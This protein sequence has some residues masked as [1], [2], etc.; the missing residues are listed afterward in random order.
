MLNI[1]NA[2]III[3][4]QKIIYDINL[5]IS[6]PEVVTI[7]GPNGSGKSTLIKLITGDLRPQSG[8]VEIDSQNVCSLSQKSRAQLI[9]VVRQSCELTSIGDFTV[10]ENLA[11][12]YKKGQR[13]S[14]FPFYNLQTKQFFLTKLSSFKNC[15]KCNLSQITSELS[16]GQKQILA[17]IMATLSN[18]RLFILDEHTSA[19]DPKS[20]MLVTEATYQISKQKNLFTIM[21]SHSLELALRFSDRII[22]LNKGKI[23]AD[24]DNDT[25]SFKTKDLMFYYH[26]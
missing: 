11:L 15:L 2:S 26:Q 8:A 9:S 4:N 12:A 19:L 22:V 14:L 6:K 13:R 18:C 3:N 16:G 17:M 21:V 10:L 25:K 20:A 5:K 23:I 24:L 7:L 1:K